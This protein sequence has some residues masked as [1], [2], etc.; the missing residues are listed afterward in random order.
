M[1]ASTPVIFAACAI[2]AFVIA[3]VVRRIALARGAVVPPRADRWHRTPTP[4]LGGIG[5]IAAIVLGVTIAGALSA[6]TVAVLSTM[7][8]LFVIGLYDDLAPLSALAKMVNSL[9]IAAF[10]VF[11]MTASGA[12]PAHAALTILAIVWFGGLD[13]AINLLDNMDGLAGG[14][15]AIAALGLA[16]TFHQELGPELVILLVAMAGGLVGFLGWNR[17]P[18]KL[19]MGNC[20]SLAIGG[21]M[22]AC[23]TYAV[24]RAGT[25]RAA[26]VAALILIVPIFDSTFVVLLRRLA[27]RSTTRGNIDHT[28]H[29]LVSA[30]FSEPRAVAIL[31]LLGI[32]GAVIGYWLHRGGE[33]MWPV[34]AAFAVGT[35]IMGLYLARV[36]AYGGQDFQALQNAPFAPLL[37]DLTFRWHAGEVLL[38]LVLI[39]TCYYGAYRIRFEGDPDL[40][41]FLRSFAQSLGVVVGCKL[42]ALYVSGLYS[43][44]WSTFGLHDLS[45]VVRGVAGGSILS[46]LAITYLYKF[47]AYSRSVFLIDAVLL[48]AAIIATRISFRML[49]RVAA[50]SSP[51]KHRVAIY[52]AGS[53]GQLLVR[54]MLAND[55]WR[56]RPIAFVDDDPATHGRRILGVPVR[57]GFDR[58]EALV[59]ARDVDE[60]LLS[61][62]AIPAQVEARVRA[63]CNPHGVSVRRLFLELR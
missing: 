8:A 30:G 20:C 38:D 5:V 49:N 6:P 46:V 19:F 3:G 52:G 24:A 33:S 14:V 45:T 43:R 12:S 59:V 11:T 18:A 37:S 42:A 36:P 29:R 34:A 63:L 21:I 39:T 31:Y 1:R 50:R 54:E 55:N 26:A 13:N 10:F 27:G 58:L 7:G 62:P 16:M 57:G 9:A 4:T 44:M 22:A 47:A 2:V 41:V 56:A 28:S 32:A 40:P 60:V 48:T 25:W 53:S 61:S 51:L 15:T 35:L 17:P 23:S